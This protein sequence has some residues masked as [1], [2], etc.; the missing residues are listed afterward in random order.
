MTRPRHEHRCA[1]QAVCSP[2][3]LSL[4]VGL[5]IASPLSA[6][7]AETYK[8]V[9]EDGGVH[10]TSDYL[11]VPESQRK[12]ARWRQGESG[13]EWQFTHGERDSTAQSD[14]SS[15]TL[16]AAPASIE[17]AP[18]PGGHGETWWR[19]RHLRRTSTVAELERRLAMLEAS[20]P[21]RRS[22]GDPD[23]ADAVRA[24]REWKRAKEVVQRDLDRERAGMRKF[25]QIA[26]SKGVPE[27]WLRPA[28]K[29]S[30]TD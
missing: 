26:Q 10:F 9:D 19:E 5:Y 29:G 12:G 27:S 14:A 25:A 7:S 11:M 18:T 17:P 6:A 2:F 22:P 21:P 3:V 30:Q 28:T 24:H 4:I 13:P 23:F 8:W 15:S 1:A 16:Q 20:D